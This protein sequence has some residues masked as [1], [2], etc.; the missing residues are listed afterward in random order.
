MLLS[1][2]PSNSER[3]GQEVKKEIKLN[4]QFT[5]LKGAKDFSPLVG[6]ETLSRLS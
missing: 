3:S 4:Q 5:L 2:E 6:T 1:L